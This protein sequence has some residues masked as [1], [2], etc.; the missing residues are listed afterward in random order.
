MCSESERKKKV[1]RLMLVSLTVF[2]LSLQQFQLI[3]YRMSKCHRINGSKV[4][5]RYYNG[6]HIRILNVFHRWCT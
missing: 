5:K 2:L 1:L 6:N 3:S 4:E